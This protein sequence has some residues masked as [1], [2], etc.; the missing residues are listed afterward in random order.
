M[1]P[2]RPSWCAR[3]KLS[4][5]GKRFP[6]VFFTLFSFSFSFFF[7]VSFSY[8]APFAPV[9]C[10]FF[11][12]P[13]PHPNCF[14]FGKG[15]R[16]IGSLHDTSYWHFTKGFFW[17]RVL[18]HES[19]ANP[20]QRINGSSRSIVNVVGGAYGQLLC[21]VHH[22]STLSVPTT[23]RAAPLMRRR[24]KQRGAETSQTWGFFWPVE[25][26]DFPPL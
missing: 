13:A 20:Q 15:S 14:S 12:F 1:N 19:L 17:L 10:F 6:R 25:K 21:H 16:I 11:F 18:L 7:P 3:L 2:S 9:P 23:S 26:E 4:L 22:Y 5:F 8:P 24:R